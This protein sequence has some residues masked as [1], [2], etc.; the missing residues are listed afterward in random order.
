MLNREP[1]A[2][3]L[4]KILRLKFFIHNLHQQLETIYS[5]QFDDKN[6]S[7]VLYREQSSLRGEFEKLMAAEG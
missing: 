5:I 2:Q 1:R 7:L 6:E 4:E 3:D